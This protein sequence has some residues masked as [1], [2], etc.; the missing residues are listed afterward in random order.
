[1][2][3]IEDIYIEMI[4]AKEADIN[5]SGLSNNSKTAIW[6]L[7]LYIVAVA[8]W[9]LEN[10]LNISINQQN[11]FIK[12][13]KI[14]SFS[15]YSLYAKKFQNGSDLPQ[16]E[17]EYDN[18]GLSD[19]DIEALEVVKYAS[20]V[21]VPGGL[22]VKIATE[23]NNELSPIANDVFE[24]FKEYMFRISAAGDQLYYTNA[25]PDSLKLELEIHYDPLVL[26][27]LGER[28]D[29]TNDTPV[30]DAI[31]DYVLG[32]D[33]D[34]KFIPT[35]LIDRLQLVEGVKIPHLVLAQTS[36][37]SLSWMDVPVTGVNPFAGYVRINDPNDLNI[38][39]IAG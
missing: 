2:R 11:N 12:Q 38:Q 25:A 10:I 23:E 13:I 32:M 27:S 6:R 30:E 1:M 21:K 20:V 29:G 5:L 33:F 22:M 14:H 37:G 16:F 17:V 36:Y 19:E 24:A 8:I 34:G 15:W 39:Y 28:L 3:T 26:N 35:K 31:N 7:M 18:A 4:T 9:S